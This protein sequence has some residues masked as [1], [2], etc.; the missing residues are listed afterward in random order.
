MYLLPINNTQ[1]RKPKRKMEAE[2]TKEKTGNPKPVSEAVKT[3]HDERKSCGGDGRTMGR[4]QTEEDKGKDGRR[5]GGR[6]ALYRS[7]SEVLCQLDDWITIVPYTTKNT[8][9]VT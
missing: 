9:T 6:E 4:P 8:T 7:S 3:L 2:N 5:E 1:V